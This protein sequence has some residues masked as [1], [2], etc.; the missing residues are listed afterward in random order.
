MS[1]F[2]WATFLTCV[3]V[4]CHMTLNL[5]KNCDMRCYCRLSVLHG[6]VLFYVVCPS[7]SS[8]NISGMLLWIFTTFVMLP[9]VNKGCA[10]LP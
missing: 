6:L 2:A 5:E 7:I 3:L 8:A 9:A 10:A 1:K 4:L